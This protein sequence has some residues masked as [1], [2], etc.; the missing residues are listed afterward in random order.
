VGRF[1]RF[2]EQCLEDIKRGTPSQFRRLQDAGEDRD[3]LR[4]VGAARP[5]A[6]LAEDGVRKTGSGNEFRPSDGIRKP[7]ANLIFA[8]RP[9]PSNAQLYLYLYLSSQPPPAARF[10]LGG[11]DFPR[12]FVVLCETCLL[13]P[14]WKGIT[15]SHKTTKAQRDKG[16]K[17]QRD[18]GTESDKGFLSGPG[19]CESRADEVAPRFACQSGRK[20]ESGNGVRHRFRWQ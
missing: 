2:G 16:T 15:Q 14:S 3:I 18:K 6:Y 10:G 7:S 8:Q 1:G 5:E 12:V 20:A 9:R 19:L 4:S 11:R 13:S 17:G